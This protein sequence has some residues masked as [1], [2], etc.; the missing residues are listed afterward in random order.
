MPVLHV[1]LRDACENYCSVSVTETD[2]T[3]HEDVVVW[4]YTRVVTDWSEIWQFQLRGPD[5]CAKVRAGQPESVE[6][7]DRAEVRKARPDGCCD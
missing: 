4:D 2:I 6:V 7:L 5:G 3:V 1:E